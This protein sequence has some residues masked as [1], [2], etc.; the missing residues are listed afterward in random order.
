M[1]VV[2]LERKLIAAA[3]VHHP[4]DSVPYAFE[5]R[6][7]A[8]LQN[9]PHFDDVALWAGALWRGAAACLT[10]VL[11]ISAV[12]FFAASRNN[13]TAN[14]TGDLAQAFENTMLASVDQD[15]DYSR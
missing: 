4:N 12:T 10:V 11:L 5:K 9:L 3:R 15:T 2:E 6:V 13:G 1:N 7:M 14:S 8:H